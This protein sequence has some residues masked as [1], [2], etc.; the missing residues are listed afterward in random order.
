MYGIEDPRIVASVRAYVK[1]MR[2]S[3]AVTAQLEV[4]LTAAG[5][6]TTQL[7][8]LEALLHL[9]PLTQRSLTTKVLTSPGNMTDL[10]EKLEQRGLVSRCRV[11]T[12]R[13]NIAVGLTAEG[14]AFIGNLFPLHAGDIAEVMKTMSD[15]EIA[16]LDTLLR[17]L[18]KA[19]ASCNVKG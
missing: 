9:G 3:R 19:A 14:Q 2:A 13:R 17:R 7:G 15:A 12:D 8:V 18:G 10:I 6:T 5:L 4:R 11:E 1:L 16:T